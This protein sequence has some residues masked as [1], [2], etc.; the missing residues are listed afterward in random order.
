M[1]FVEDDDRED[2]RGAEEE[3]EVE[4][5]A[6]EV[7]G[8]ERDVGRRGKED[9]QSI[10]SVLLQ[11]FASSTSFSASYVRTIYHFL[12]NRTGFFVHHS[13][14]CAIHS[15]ST[16]FKRIRT[17][18]LKALMQLLQLQ[19][20]MPDMQQDSIRSSIG[21]SDRMMKEV[22]MRGNLKRGR[23]YHQVQ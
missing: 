10:H 23:D 1:C 16:K 4:V 14:T 8:R 19:Q 21:P 5:D 15:L 22:D 20:G 11:Y 6:V 3:E 2:E 13:T 18:W 17:R 12:Q 9:L 7:D